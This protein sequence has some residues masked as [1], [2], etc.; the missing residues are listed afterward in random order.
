MLHGANVFIQSAEGDLAKQTAQIEDFISRKVSVIY[1]T[2][3]TLISDR[4]PRFVWAL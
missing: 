4:I 1:D 2:L 3:R